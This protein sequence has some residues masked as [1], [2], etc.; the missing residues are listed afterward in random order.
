[1]SKLEW[2]VVTKDKETIESSTD[3][4]TTY[5]EKTKKFDA[6]IK[7]D[8]DWKV[9]KSM[10]LNLVTE[11]KKSLTP[12]KESNAIAV[13]LQL[14]DNAGNSDKATKEVY[15]VDTT[16]PSVTVEYDNNDAKNEYY[17]DKPRKA[18]ITVTDAN[19]SSAGCRI[20]I[21][22]GSASYSDWGHAP[23]GNCDGKNHSK[24]CQYTCTVDF[25]QD[26]EYTFGFSCTDLAVR[27]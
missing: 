25:S 15:S 10:D 9:S 6:N 3:I 8:A 2:N 1:M 5:N 13:S 11:M 4:T 24:D 18:T 17:Y 23:G 21:G 14:T 26:G 7:G 16:A 27:I 22:G 20:Q 19:F 12:N